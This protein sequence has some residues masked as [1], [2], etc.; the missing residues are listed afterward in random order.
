M[1]NRNT[2]NR[3]SML[4][5]NKSNY[6]I[7]QKKK[8]KESYLTFINPKRLHKPKTIFYSHHFSPNNPFPR[9]KHLSSRFPPLERE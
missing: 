3:I 6:N 8:R 9:Q 7:V 5:P 2:K 4:Y 1:I